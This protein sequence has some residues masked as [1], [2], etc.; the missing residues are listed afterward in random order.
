MMSLRTLAKGALT[1]L[2]AISL[3]ACVTLLP[4][5]KPAQLYRFGQ[6]EEAAAPRATPAGAV[7]V[8]WLDGAFQQEAAGDRILTVTGDKAAYIAEARWVAPAQSLFNQAAAA[9]F[10]AAGGRVRL[11]SHGAP[12][13]ADFA[14][15]LDVRQFETRYPAPGQTPTV[16]VRV[17]ATLS[18]GRGPAAEQMFDAAVPA[19]D[20]RVSA[21][22]A[23][24]DKAVTDLLTQVVGW[25]NEKAG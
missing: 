22:A 4:K 6:G 8:Y 11:A 2:T 3:A 17:H 25:T 18:R 9:A 7:G 16:M 15:R 5:T 21:I 13:T 10:D 24:Y 12:T 20:N 1:A 19:S 23:A 14:L